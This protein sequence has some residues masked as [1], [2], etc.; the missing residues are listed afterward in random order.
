M[1]KSKVKS[2][3]KGFIIEG[4]LNYDNKTIEVEEIGDYPFDKVFEQFN[5]KTV[6]L[7]IKEPDEEILSVPEEE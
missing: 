1:G 3:G 6:K 7:T 4:I 5:G 2:T